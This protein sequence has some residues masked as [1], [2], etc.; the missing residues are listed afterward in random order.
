MLG[1]MFKENKENSTTLTVTLEKGEDGFVV[2]ECLEI[3]GCI[4]QGKD[5]REAMEN[6]QDAIRA[7]LEVQFMQFI[8]ERP[9][10]TLSKTATS[11][12][13]RIKTPEL[14]LVGA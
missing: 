9:E 5:E 12:S 4:S 11:K 14:E 3:P 6:I 13:I 1:R 7:C 10:R 8:H 2:A